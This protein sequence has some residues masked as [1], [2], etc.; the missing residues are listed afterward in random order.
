MIRTQ[1]D[2]VAPKSLDEA[3]AML[4]TN[5]EARLLAGGH[6]LLGQLKT[7]QISPKLLVDLRQVPGLKDIGR[8]PGEEGLFIG[9]M[10]TCAELAAHPEV[11]ANYQALVEAANSIGDA[12]VRNRA[13]LGGNLGTGDPAADLAATAL[14]LEATLYVVGPFGSRT[15]GAG[16]FFIGPFE[17][18][19]RGEI[20][21]GIKFPPVPARRGSAYEKIKNPAN[22]YPICGVAAAVTLTEQNSLAECRLAVTGVAA[23]PIHLRKGEASLEKAEATAQNIAAAA[24]QATQGLTCVSDLFAS[25]EYRAHLSRV[26]AERALTRAVERAGQAAANGE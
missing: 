18:A 25:G 16:E 7:R 3:V 22:G 9:A 19:L 4:Q 17:T 12:Q 1:F 14:A 20:I 6:S 26:L 21:T 15:I 24:E 13:T 2:Y 5:G 11:Q 10:T 23:H 8:R